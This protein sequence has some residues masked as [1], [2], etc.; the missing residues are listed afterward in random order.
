MQVFAVLSWVLVIF[1]GEDKWCKW[2]HR[3]QHAWE[4]LEHAPK[5][6]EYQGE[7]TNEC[8]GL[9]VSDIVQKLFSKKDLYQACCI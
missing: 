8:R 9:A 4:S 7:Q 3:V 6:C 2:E 5:C 1:I